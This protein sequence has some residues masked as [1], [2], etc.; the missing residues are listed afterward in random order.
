[1]NNKGS[2][3]SIGPNKVQKQEKISSSF[4]EK[5]CLRLAKKFEK[6]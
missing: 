6:H 1:M 2:G 5:V 4:I 3:L